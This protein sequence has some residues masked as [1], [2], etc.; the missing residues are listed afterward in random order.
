MLLFQTTFNT[1][2][3]H[4]RNRARAGWPV[5]QPDRSQVL[6]DYQARDLKIIK[7]NCN[8]FYQSLV[9]TSTVSTPPAPTLASPS[10]S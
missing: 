4:E 2:H 7:V 10:C 9:V 6:G 3:H 8:T 1:T 5:R